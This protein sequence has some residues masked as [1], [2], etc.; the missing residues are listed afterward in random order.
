[1][2]WRGPIALVALVVASS[3]SSN[4]PSAK[5]PSAPAI[6]TSAGPASNELPTADLLE[7]AALGIKLRLPDRKAWS[8]STDAS[9]W[10]VLKKD[11]TIVRLT[12]TEETSMIG[13]AQCELRAQWVGEAPNARDQKR[14]HFETVA[15]ESA[16]HPAGWDAL[17][18]VAIE[19]TGERVIGHVFYFASRAQTCLIAHAQLL[20]GANETAEN[21]A[22]RLEIVSTVTIGSITMISNS[23]D[24][25][26]PSLDAN[27]L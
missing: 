20:K 4:A 25:S 1:V 8:Q 15:R 12:K 14:R 21:L 2:R 22:D 7:I 23:P 5:S 9:G 3:C 17:H 11:D 24:R 26:L 13:S 27:K 6:A 18:W 10:T 19:V 16:N